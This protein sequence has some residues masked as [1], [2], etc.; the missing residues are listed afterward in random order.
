MVAAYHLPFLPFILFTMAQVF[1]EPIDRESSSDLHEVAPT[2]SPSPPPPLISFNGVQLTFLP[3]VSSP[4]TQVNSQEPASSLEMKGA[5]QI[6]VFGTPIPR[7]IL[8]SWLASTSNAG[9]QHITILVLTSKGTYRLQTFNCEEKQAILLQSVSGEFSVVDDIMAAQPDKGAG[10]Y[11]HIRI[12]DD[13][14]YLQDYASP[15]DPEKAAVFRKL[16]EVAKPSNN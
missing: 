8:G 9:F 6:G 1:Q 12:H 13:K 3:R 10:V 14:L 5:E 11:L 7:K 15:F 4:P 2:V 16:T